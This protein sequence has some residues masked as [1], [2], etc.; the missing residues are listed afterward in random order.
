M[1]DY[2]TI[3]YFLANYMD[4]NIGYS[5]EEILEGLEDE[6]TDEDFRESMRAE[7]SSALEDN[8]F[9]WMQLFA[10]HQAGHFETEEAARRYVTKLLW[11]TVFP[12]KALPIS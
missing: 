7:L 6:L 11:N 1:N 8:A 9:S 10:E 12:D 2:E 5:E 4:V 3:T